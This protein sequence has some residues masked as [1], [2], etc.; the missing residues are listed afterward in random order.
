MKKLLIP[1]ALVAIVIGCSKQ[2]TPSKS[3]PPSNN[4]A[5]VI[6]D[7]PTASSTP[8][9]TSTNTPISTNATNGADGSRNPATRTGPGNSQDAIDGMA[10]YNQKCN[11]CHNYKI[12][13]DY[14]WDRWASIM[15]VMAMRANLTEV[16]KQKVLA[17]VHANAK[18]G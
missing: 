1:A 11:K 12:T 6:V 8:S 14:T 18:A 7:K 17:Y 13:T 5:P 9:N 15:Q 4:S 16:E 10:I 3:M 2:S